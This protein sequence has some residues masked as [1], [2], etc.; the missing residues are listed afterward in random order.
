MTVLFGLQAG[1]KS[2]RLIRQEDHHR[3][4]TWT[5]ISGQVIEI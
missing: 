2:I 3:P 5:G 1:A 4:R